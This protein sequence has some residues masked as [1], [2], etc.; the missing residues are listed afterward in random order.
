MGGKVL[1]ECLHQSPEHGDALRLLLIL[2]NSANDFTYEGKVF[3][4]DLSRAMDDLE[5]TIIRELLDTLETH[6]NFDHVEVYPNEDYEDERMTVDYRL[7][8]FTKEDFALAEQL[9]FNKNL[10]VRVKA[11]EPEG[12][13]YLLHCGPYYK[14]GRTV[15]LEKRLPQLAIQLPYKPELI[16]TIASKTPDLTEDFFHRIFAEK[17]MNGEWF[18]LNEEDIRYFCTMERLDMTR[19]VTSIHTLPA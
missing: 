7:Q 10:A 15:D 9:L 19:E 2:A 3:I 4:S 1:S 8:I 18:R 5:P 6:E 13:I 11:Y 17:R 16:H 12:Y 14:I